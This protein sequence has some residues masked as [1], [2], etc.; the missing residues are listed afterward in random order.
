MLLALHRWIAL[1]SAVAISSRWVWQSVFVCAR[2]CG[3]CGVYS[4]LALGPNLFSFGEQLVPFGLC[5]LLLLTMPL[6]SLNRAEVSVLSVRSLSSCALL[7]L[8]VL[9]NL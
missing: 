9:S 2:V 3:V 7:C 1:R 5:C 6:L 4:L 8:C